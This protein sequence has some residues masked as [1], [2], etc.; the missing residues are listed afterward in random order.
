MNKNVSGAAEPSLQVQLN[1]SSSRR[2]PNTKPLLRFASGTKSKFLL[3]IWFQPRF[4]SPVP[5]EFLGFAEHHKG[6]HPPPKKHLERAS[7]STALVRPHHA[8]DS[9]E[10]SQK[11]T[12]VVTQKPRQ[13]ICFVN[14]VGEP[15]LSRR[16]KIS[17]SQPWRSTAERPVNP[18]HPEKPEQSRFFLLP[19]TALLGATEMKFIPP[20]AQGDLEP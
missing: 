6:V 11:A 2:T 14:P 8:G 9:P 12:M 1:T 13:C 4:P 3:K 18:R 17:T 19:T 5:T 15:S 16:C 20:R 7:Y 10:I